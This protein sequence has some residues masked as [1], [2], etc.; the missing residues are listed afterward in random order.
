MWGTKVWG[1][2][3]SIT[4]PRRNLT[5]P[6]SITSDDPDC[7]DQAPADGF[8]ITV[9]R[10]FKKGGEE[11]KRESYNTHYDPTDKITCVKPGSSSSP[12]PG[13]SGSASPTKSPKPPKSTSTPGPSGDP[14]S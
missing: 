8:D 2:I 5:S 9:T 14:S 4:G 11:V 3:Q 10:V 7:D 13:A 1:D 6:K 12:S